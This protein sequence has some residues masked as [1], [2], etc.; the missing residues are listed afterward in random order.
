[1]VVK[2]KLFSL[3]TDDQDNTLIRPINWNDEHEIDAQ[4]L[5][6]V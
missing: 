6:G 1:M 3:K 5:V 4:A 2:H